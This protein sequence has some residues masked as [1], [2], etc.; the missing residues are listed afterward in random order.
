LVAIERAIAEEC[1]KAPFRLLVAVGKLERGG[2]AATADGIANDPDA[3]AALR[4]EVAEVTNDIDLISTMGKGVLV[5]Q[6]LIGRQLQAYEERISEATL[7]LRRLA[8]EVLDGAPG[9]MLADVDTSK[10]RIDMGPASFDPFPLNSSVTLLRA[11]RQSRFLLEA[12]EE[13]AT[14]V[15]GE[16]A[17]GGSQASQR[18]TP[19]W[20]GPGG[21]RDVGQ[22]RDGRSVFGGRRVGGGYEG[23]G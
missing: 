8:V 23:R 9:L 10:G 3:I 18:P 20:A 14:R 1:M 21:G 15:E 17:V 12:T 7:T 4:G 16:P 6:R 19:R 11:L 2:F 22:R 13:S 5:G